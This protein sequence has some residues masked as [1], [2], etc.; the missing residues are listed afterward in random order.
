MGKKKILIIML[1]LKTG[2]A[3]RSCVA[4]LRTLPKDKYDVDLMLLSCEGVLLKQVPAWVNIIPAPHTYACLDHRLKD[5]RFYIRHS[6]LLWIKKALR[7]WKAKRHSDSSMNFVQRLYQ[8]WRSNLPVLEK[9]YDV[10]IGYLE[11]LCNYI[12]S[13]KVCANRKILWVHNNYDDL[14]YFPAFD[15]EYFAKADVIATMSPGACVCLQRNFPDLS[16]HIWFIENITDAETV[17]NMSI[18]HIPEKGLIRFDGLRIVSCGR[19]VSQK[20]Y[21]RAIEAAS[22]L[23]K[24]RIPFK[25]V[26]VGDGPEKKKLKHLKKRM[27]VNESLSLL[28]MR[29]NPYPYMKWADMLVVTSNYEGRSMVIDEAKI[30][31]IPVVTTNY[32]TAVDAVEHEQTGLICEMS[33]EAIANAIIRLYNDK[34]LYEHIRSKLL[35]TCYGNCEEIMKY[36][37]AIEGCKI[38]SIRNGL[39]LIK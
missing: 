8:Q 34:L 10:A 9:E 38:E 29:E 35:G 13:E 1:S 36:I 17:R 7:I 20:A 5:W 18:Q 27:G 37:E 23:Q 21:E 3:K 19:L 39:S 16:D 26:I 30:L 4:F 24:R 12:V 6:P 33:P 2:G 15:A 28:G 31:G 25:W 22:L 14:G 32:A 11:G